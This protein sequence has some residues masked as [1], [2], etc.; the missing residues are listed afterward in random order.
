MKMKIVILLVALLTIGRMLAQTPVD[1]TG[2]VLVQDSEYIATQTAEIERLLAEVRIRQVLDSLAAQY[3]PTPRFRAKDVVL[4]AAL[5]A[6]GTVA[7]W[8]HNMCKA[9][10]H[11]HDHLEASHTRADDYLQWAPMAVGIGMHIGGLRSRYAP[12]DDM[13]ATLNSVAL[14]Y[15]VGAAMKYGIREPRP[16]DATERNS[17]PSGHTA[18]A[19][20]SAE[21]LRMQYGNWWGLGGYAIA[22]TV[23]YLRLRN[24]KYWLN[25]VVGGAGLGILCARAGYWLV[26]FEK[27]LFGWENRTQ[28]MFGAVPYYDPANRAFG[29]SMAM[30]F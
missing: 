11:I 29:A 4:P 26:P 20:R 18:R 12:L 5:L 15:G 17:F 21:M 2:A 27:R 14:M 9:K 25:D 1:S 30:R 22:T 13:L 24:G 10:R 7:V 6:V 3:A 8:E 23:A 16:Y 19:F 28:V